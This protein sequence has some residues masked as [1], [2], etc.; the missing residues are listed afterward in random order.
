MNVFLF[1]DNMLNLSNK[2]Q[3]MIDYYIFNIYGKP[4]IFLRQSINQIW[5]NNY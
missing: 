3:T 5:D 4:R 2:D 1:E